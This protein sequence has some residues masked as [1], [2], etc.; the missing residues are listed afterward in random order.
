MLEVKGGVD[1]FKITLNPT[2]KAV[3]IF[4]VGF[5]FAHISFNKNAQVLFS[6]IFIII[7]SA[8]AGGFM[9]Y[10]ILIFINDVKESK[11]FKGLINRISNNIKNA[12]K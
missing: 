8:L 5:A 1:D 7:I 10:G 12:F 3:F 11:S 4:Y 2:L 9:M 6:D